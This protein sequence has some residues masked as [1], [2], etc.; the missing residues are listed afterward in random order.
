MR[1]I[2]LSLCLLAT[3]SSI[4]G[5]S[6]IDDDLAD[7]A[8]ARTI[9]CRLHPYGDIDSL[10]AAQITG[11]GG[12]ILINTL[13]AYYRSVLYPTS[14]TVNLSFYDAATGELCTTLTETM[15]GMSATFTPQLPVGDLRCDGESQQPLYR[16]SALMPRQQSRDTIDLYPVEAQVA[17][18]AK[19]NPAVT[20][21]QMVVGSDSLQYRQTASTADFRTYAAATLPSGSSQSWQV[22]IYATLT[23]GSVTRTVL[24]VQRPLVAGDIRV[25][26]VTIGSNGAAETSNIGVGASVT[27][28]WKRG[29]QYDPTI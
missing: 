10:L 22:T 25:L 13:A 4:C 20:S 1:H 23:D 26:Q 18:V 7:C 19:V 6:L 5:C 11:N 29:G 16:G 27:L 12:Q 24:T 28:D 21:V 3:L 2:I 17:V 14:R 8:T 15:Q 9:D